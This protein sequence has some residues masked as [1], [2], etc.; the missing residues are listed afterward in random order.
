[1]LGRWTRWGYVQTYIQVTNINIILIYIPMKVKE[2]YT[3]I[4]EDRKDDDSM[5]MCFV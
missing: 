3:E 4:E 5:D 1:M 2:L